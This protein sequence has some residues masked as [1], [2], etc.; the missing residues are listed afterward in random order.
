[1]CILGFNYPEWVISDVA[2][3]FAG[4]FAN[5]IYPTNGPKACKYILEY[6]N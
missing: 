4:G 3:I 5:V 6:S 2:A 1:M